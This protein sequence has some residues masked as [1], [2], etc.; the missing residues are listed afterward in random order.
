MYT[1]TRNNGFTLIEMLVVIVLLSM[2]S[3]VGYQSVVF[4]VK[5]WEGGEKIMSYL[6]NDYQS[7]IHFVSWLSLVP[8]SFPRM[9]KHDCFF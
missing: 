3:I 1:L 4:V 5:R 8:I 2:M 6:L 7:V 9:T